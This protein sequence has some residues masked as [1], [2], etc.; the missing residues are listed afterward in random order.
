[1]RLTVRSRLDHAQCVGAD[2]SQHADLSTYCWFGGLDPTSSFVCLTKY[3]STARCCSC[4][5]SPFADSM[6]TP[7]HLAPF[8]CITRL[9]PPATTQSVFY[10]TIL[11][12][13]CAS[14]SKVGWPYSAMLRY[15]L[16]VEWR[17][18]LGIFYTKQRSC[19][20]LLHSR[21]S[22]TII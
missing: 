4:P 18:K 11:D 8:P 15:I 9:C 7:L 6:M 20:V 22:D 10:G 21:I 2:V 5:I 19:I 12:S 13:A 1:M 17:K 14:R 3:D 16:Q